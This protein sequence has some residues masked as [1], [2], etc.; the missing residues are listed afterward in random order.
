M[1]VREIIVINT[2]DT[3]EAR[4]DKGKKHN[5]PASRQTRS[6]KGT[7]H[8]YARLNEIS[9]LDKG[10]HREQYTRSAKY[11]HCQYMKKLSAYNV[12]NSA[13]EIIGDT[14]VFDK[15]GIST[16]KPKN[17]RKLKRPD[18]RVSNVRCTVK[19]TLEEYKWEW[20][21]AKALEDKSEE[22]KDKKFFCNHYFVKEDEFDLWDFEEWKNKY[23]KIIT[24]STDGLI[25]DLIVYDENKNEEVKSDGNKE[26]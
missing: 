12:Y 14:I 17:W 2:T 8:N 24:A 13:G 20:L 23:E 26:V 22:Q 6:D 16:M 4:R 10:S 21:R 7:V 5:Y 15:N 19:K 9:R 1:E 25:H 3:T 18:G 11:Y